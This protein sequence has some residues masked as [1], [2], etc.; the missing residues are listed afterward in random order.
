MKDI[1]KPMQRRIAQTCIGVSSLRNQGAKGVNE[2]ARDYLESLS[3]RK[4]KQ[5]SMVGFLKILDETTEELKRQFPKNAQNWG[6]SR[7]AVNL[8]LRDVLYNRCL[9]E[10]YRLVPIE[11]FLEIPLDSYVVKKLLSESH[12]ILPK[13]KGIKL[14]EKDDSDL[15]QKE[16]LKHAQMKKTNRIHLDLVWWREKKDNAPE[17]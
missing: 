13:W 17:A 3:L 14:L 11:P 6:A 8:F 16:A 15:Y 4:F 2:A 7:K 9:S 12:T 1:H 10:Y 5:P